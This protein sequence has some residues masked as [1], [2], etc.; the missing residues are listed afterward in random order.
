MYIIEC[1]FC[2]DSFA[3]STEAAVNA[4]YST[5]LHEHIVNGK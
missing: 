4:L 5:H 3:R 2:K 1:P